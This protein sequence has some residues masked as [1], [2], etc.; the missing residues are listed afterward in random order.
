MKRPAIPVPTALLALALAAGAARAQFAQPPPDQADLPVDAA[1]RRA[2]VESLATDVAANYVFPETGAKVARALRDKLAHG[3]YDR[4]A[5]AKELKDSLN[6]DLRAVAHDL[7]LRV[8]YYNRSLPVQ[9]GGHGEAPTSPAEAARAAEPDRMRKY[10]FERV[11]RLPGNVGY[12]DLR[13]FDGSAAAGEVAQA[14]LQFLGHTDALIV[15]LRKNGGGDPNMVILLLSHLYPDD[16]RVHVNDFYEREGNRTE[17]FW[18]TTS[19]P[20]PRFVGKDLYV[21]TSRYTG[22]CAEEFAYDAK[23]LKRG[24]LIGETTAGGA[25]PGRAFRLNEHFAAFVATGRAIN[26]VTHTN[27]EGVG[28]EPDVKVPAE[29]ALRTAHVA[30]LTALRAKATDDDR[31]ALLDRALEFAKATPDDAPIAGGPGPRRAPVAAGAPQ[32]H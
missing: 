8:Q 13:G 10:G 21:L 32:G 24:T 4:I 31:R 26:P 5:G 30:A 23:S 28:V 9:G 2:T 17:E 1:F 16:E 12:I 3:R 25:N 18:T 11:E 19:V 6:A 22:S 15:D 7:H 27:W 14:A 29:Q 20:G